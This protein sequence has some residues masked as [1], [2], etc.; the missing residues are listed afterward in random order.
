MFKSQQAAA[1]AASTRIYAEDAVQ[2]QVGAAAAAG[3]CQV[4]A[5][6]SRCCELP[7]CFLH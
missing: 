4:V 7:A 2:F 1:I 3:V 5:G 6:A